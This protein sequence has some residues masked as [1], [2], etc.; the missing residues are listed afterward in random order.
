MANK[1]LKSPLCLG[2]HFGQIAFYN[3]SAQI[4][5]TFRL[6]AELGFEFLTNRSVMIQFSVPASVAIFII[7]LVPRQRVFV[8]HFLANQL[9]PQNYH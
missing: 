4:L 9:T 8:K 1:L 5:L 7:S 2:L 3:L 6:D